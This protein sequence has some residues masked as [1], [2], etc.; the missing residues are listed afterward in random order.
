[1]HQQLKEGRFRP[2]DFRLHPGLGNSGTHWLLRDVHGRR[3]LQEQL[4]EVF[5]EHAARVDDPQR[6][7]R[8]DDMIAFLALRGWSRPVSQPG[9]LLA[10]LRILRMIAAMRWRRARRA[11][12]RGW[13]R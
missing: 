2:S 13:A 6:E 7:R 3:L 8:L 4:R 11:A 10:V 12:V 1:M 5:P 9:H